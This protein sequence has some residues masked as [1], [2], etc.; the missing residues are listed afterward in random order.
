MDSVGHPSTL[1]RISSFHLQFSGKRNVQVTRCASTG[2]E[3][4]KWDATNWSRNCALPIS[5]SGRPFPA[6]HS[7]DYT[8]GDTSSREIS[9]LDFAFLDLRSP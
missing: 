8:E 3:A 7:D 6:A 1:T 9:G 5:L 4:L 2:T